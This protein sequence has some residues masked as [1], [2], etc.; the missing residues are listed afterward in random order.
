MEMM[1]EV[2]APDSD[3]S[4]VSRE[5]RRLVRIAYRMLGSASDAEDVAQEAW[6]RWCRLEPTERALVDRPGAWLTT[7]TTRLALDRLKHLRRARIDYVGPWIPEPVLTGDAGDEDPATVADLAES[8]TLGFLTVLERLGPLERAVFVLV[9]IFGESHAEAARMVNRSESTCRQILHRA[10]ERVRTD[11]RRFEP[12]KADDALMAAFLQAATS[13]DLG[14]LRILL[15]DDVV[16]L[17]DGGAAVHAARSAVE[18]VDRV[19]RFV[20]NV[21]KRI[22]PDGRFEL[23]SI[24]GEPGA[25]LWYGAELFAA[26]VC[27]ARDNRLVTIRLVRNPDKLGALRAGWELT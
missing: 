26:I 3:G 27:S 25:R 24:N 21:A 6:L 11:R 16:L 22:G 13:G 2:V 19:T 8:L 9:D 5:H 10:R 23:G 1:T 20:V 17:S 12:G 14:G 18:G 4:L 7:V 15:A